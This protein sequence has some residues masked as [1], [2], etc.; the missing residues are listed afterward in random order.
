MSIDTPTQ[1]GSDT[2]SPRLKLPGP[3]LTDPADVPLDITALRD[4]LDPVTVV[5]SQGLANSMPAAGVTGRYYWATDTK[6]LYYDDGTSW[7]QPG[8]TP[9]GG[10][11]PTASQ[12]APQGWLLCNGA[13]YS[14]S[15]YAVLFNA[16]GLSWTGTD[17]GATFNVPDLRGRMPVG[18]G[19]GP[20]LTNRLVG[21]RSGSETQGLGVNEMP[22]HAHGVN[23][24]PHVHGVYDPPH[25]HTQWGAD[26]LWTYGGGG[27]Q[28][29][30]V[31]GSWGG[32]QHGVAGSS[33]GVQI[34]GAATGVS[35]QNAGGGAPH[36]NMPPFAAVNWL[37]KT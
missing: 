5:F 14:R 35:I 32:N 29:P 31:I 1:T 8:S 27:F 12:L 19:Q 37:I 15:T 4:A 36:N 3:V 13:Q 11:L 18:A 9:A 26:T 22:V 21:T 34:Y 24:P 20:G 28:T 23:D 2:P 7:Y 30:T 16:I 25:G 17:D 33:T 6:V 10:L